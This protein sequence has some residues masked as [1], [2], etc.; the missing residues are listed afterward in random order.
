MF[1]QANMFVSFRP[2]LSIHSAQKWV[3]QDGEFYTAT[4]SP[5]GFTTTSVKICDPVHFEWT[6][7]THLRVKP[8]SARDAPEGVVAKSF[9]WCN[10]FRNEF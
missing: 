10:L 7:S 6:D 2:H 1:L 4:S 3:F 9:L 5:D 8:G